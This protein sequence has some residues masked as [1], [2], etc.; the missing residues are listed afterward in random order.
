M[1]NRLCF[2]L[3]ESLRQNLKFQL[4]RYFRTLME[5]VGADTSRYERKEMALEAIVHLFRVPNLAGELYLNYDCGLYCTNL[6]EDL[7]KLLSENAFPT[8]GIIQSTH[9]LSLE[10]LLTII[11][12]ICAN[13][14]PNLEGNYLNEHRGEYK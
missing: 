4:E 12:K 9:V 2:L 7:T 3:F 5:I 13:S 10:A 1:A 14:V 8:T 11:N 6:F